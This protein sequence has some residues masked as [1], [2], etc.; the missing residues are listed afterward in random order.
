M[1]S[2]VIVALALLAITNASIIRSE[3]DTRDPCLDFT[4]SEGWEC[5]SIRNPSCLFAQ[6]RPCNPLLPRCIRK[7]AVL[8]AQRASRCPPPSGVG[9]CAF[10]CQSD[11]DCSSG[12]KCCRNGCGGTNCMTPV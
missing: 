6:S 11:N 8:P 1:H 4:C 12:Q 5:K 7:P 9:L 3:V 2:I 10:M